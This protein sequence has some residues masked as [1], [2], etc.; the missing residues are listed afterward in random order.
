MS[1]A[2]IAAA[3]A[4]FNAHID[5]CPRSSEW[6]YGARA[7]VW[8]A[9]GLPPMPSPWPSGSAADDARNAGFQH[10]YEQARHDLAAGARV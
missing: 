4:W 3:R 9:H 8:K 5:R 7:G 10:G 2:T 1:A 6:K